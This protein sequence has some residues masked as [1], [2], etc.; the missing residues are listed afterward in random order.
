MAALAD[1]SKGNTTNLKTFLQDVAK[2]FSEQ[3]MKDVINCTK[4][5]LRGDYNKLPDDDLTTCF[6]LLRKHGLVSETDTS[7]IEFY[8]ETFR[9]EDATNGPVT[10]KINEFKRRIHTANQG[11]ALKGQ[12]IGRS[13]DVH[14]ILDELRARPQASNSR[15]IIGGINLH[16]EGGVGKT[17]LAK[18]IAKKLCLERDC[19]SIVVNLRGIEKMKQVYSAVLHKFHRTPLFCSPERIYDSIESLRHD[20]VLIFDNAEDLLLNLQDFKGFITNMIQR[21]EKQRL[22]LVLTSRLILHGVAQFANYF[23]KPF[24]KNAS[25]ELLFQKAGVE[26]NID[27]A[28]EIAEKCSNKP[29]L[30]KGIA[31]IL[32]EN[33]AAPEEVLAKI[34]KNAKASC[35]AT[36]VIQE[37][38]EQQTQTEREVEPKQPATELSNND[39]AVFQ[40]MFSKLAKPLMNSLVK[41]SLLC[42]D[43]PLHAAQQILGRSTTETR[44]YLNILISKGCVESKRDEHGEKMFDLHPLIQ[45][46]LENVRNTPEY[47]AV[48]QEA[49]VLFCSLFKNKLKELAL[50]SDT[51]F[52]QVFSDFEKERPNFEQLLKLSPERE[53]LSLL[54][55]VREFY[56][57][58]C[59]LEP[60][61][62]V[63]EREY[64][65]H[66]WA[67]IAVKEGEVQEML[68]GVLRNM[69]FYLLARELMLS[70]AKLLLETNLMKLNPTD[71]N[72]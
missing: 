21:D 50:R 42:Q 4:N 53:F 46:F 41:L 56:L 31:A 58:P 68:A 61:L 52:I 29:L 19:K 64:L 47:Q 10:K 16:G 30:L 38:V 1:I 69:S 62:T 14:Q 48:Y 22:K 8:A 40:E 24:E 57:L 25:R 15:E 18:E 37:K 35:K 71:Q 36:K 63:G 66:K 72:K 60:L 49:K 7:A 5:D 11:T 34:E 39:K 2:S 65:F 54:P 32:K 59:L 70:K 67:D 43:F 12:I 45:K 17:W 13:E 9:K 55:D 33:L 23:V 26:L 28:V 20:L 27:V 3:E 51:D 6:E 44:Y